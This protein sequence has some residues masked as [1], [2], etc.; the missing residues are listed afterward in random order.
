MILFD[1][2]HYYLLGKGNKIKT[3]SDINQLNL[4]QLYNCYKRVYCAKEQDID[5]IR[6]LF[7]S[8]KDNINENREK[9]VPLRNGKLIKPDST[10]IPELIFIKELIVKKPDLIRSRKIYEEMVK[11][12]EDFRKSFFYK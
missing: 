12:I 6:Q 11:K 3:N 7:E 8:H 1:R 9:L 2:R 10:F 4:L 5:Y